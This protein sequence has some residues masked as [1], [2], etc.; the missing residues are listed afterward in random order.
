MPPFSILPLV[1][2]VLTVLLR[3][4]DSEGHIDILE[5]RI[6][7]VEAFI[8]RRN[9]TFILGCVVRIW[10]ECLDSDMHVAAQRE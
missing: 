8:E 3:S 6:E 4:S 10:A 7:I 2:I 1:K 5:G 9:D